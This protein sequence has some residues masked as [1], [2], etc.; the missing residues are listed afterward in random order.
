MKIKFVT[1]T[2]VALLTAGAVTAQTTVT[3]TTTTT[4]HVWTDPNAWWGS[5]WAYSTGDRYTANELSLDFFA[6]YLAGERRAEDLFKTNI[7]HGFWGG[8]V[9][10][11]YFFTRNIGIGADMN[12][13]DDGGG[14]FIN[15]VNGSLIARFPIAQSGL[16]PYVF[17]G[18]GRQTDPAWEWTG[19]AGV[20]VEYRFNPVTG[21]FTDARYTWVKHTSDEILFRA[22]LR[23]VF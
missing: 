4:T 14:N 17:G 18:G 8:G 3:E 15:N 16:A 9:G 1:L 11:N 22:G 21:L 2:A 23:F 6:S 7:R 5:H 13:P 12:I 20:G 10:A 19:H